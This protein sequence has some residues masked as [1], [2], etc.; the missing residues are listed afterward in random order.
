LAVPGTVSSFGYTDMVEDVDGYPL[1]KHVAGG[2]NI[3]DWM[4]AHYNNG[5]GLTRFRSH[6]DKRWQNA[7]NARVLLGRP[8]RPLRCHR[9]RGQDRTGRDGQRLRAGAPGRRQGLRAS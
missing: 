2:G 5:S 1:A 7:T 9:R 6:F 3:V 4:K 8:R